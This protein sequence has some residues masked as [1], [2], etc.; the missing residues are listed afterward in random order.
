MATALC[1][2]TEIFNRH[3]KKLPGDPGNF[4]SEGF[5]SEGFTGKGFT[6]KGFT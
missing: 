1:F 6:G 3:I 4:L 2:S 5:T